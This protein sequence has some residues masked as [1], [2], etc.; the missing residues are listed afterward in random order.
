MPLRR[1][2]RTATPATPRAGLLDAV[3]EKAAAANAEALARREGRDMVG[4]NGGVQ[5]LQ[6]VPC[7]LTERKPELCANVLSKMGCLAITEVLS[8]A[9]ADTLLAFVNA[10]NARC[11]A[12]VLAERVSFD[13]RFGGVNCRGMSGPFGQRQDLFLPVRAPEVQAALRELVGNLGPLLRVLVGEGAMLHE[14]SSIVAEPQ[15]PRQCVHADTIVLP[16]PQFPDVSM[17]PLYT[18]FVA[19]QDV[20]NDMG[21]TQFLP[22]THTPAAHELWNAATK[23]ERLK[24]RFIGAQPAVRS[25]LRKGDTAVFDSRVLHCGCANDS[26]TRRVLFY[27]TLSAAQDWPLPNGLHGSNSVRA[28]DR[29]KW[30]L[31]DLGLTPA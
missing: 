28:E 29:W 27:I 5:L 17:A 10:E 3:M 16:C 18:F 23:S 7:S 4:R 2:N 19:L 24:E 21:H 14:I 8:P 9:S 31:L 15:S 6:A 30:R 22:Y 20:Q 11:Q 1:R 13:D 12:D 25:A 26:P